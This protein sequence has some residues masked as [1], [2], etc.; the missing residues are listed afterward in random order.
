[1][2]KG[3]ARHKLEAMVAA[4]G[5]SWLQ[6]VVSRTV[7]VREV[8]DLTEI[9]E[10]GG[11]GQGAICGRSR[12][13]LIEINDA[14]KFYSMIA[15]VGDVESQF[16]RERMLYAQSPVLYVRTAEITVHAEGVARTWVGSSAWHLG[17]VNA[18]H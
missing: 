6:P 11:K 1:M 8:V 2:R 15:N 12:W 3:V 5:Q 14:G 9:R 4:R 10:I 17:A 16:A 18:M 13:S 7:K